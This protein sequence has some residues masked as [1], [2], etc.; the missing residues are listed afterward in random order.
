MAKR[1]LCSKLHSGPVG[2]VL[3]P[4]NVGLYVGQTFPGV[5]VCY[6]QHN[7]GIHFF[8]QLLENDLRRFFATVRLTKLDSW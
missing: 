1:W 8:M 7:C 6:Y 5:E 2:S 4:Q 3:L